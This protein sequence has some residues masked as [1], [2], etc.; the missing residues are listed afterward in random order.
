M[1]RGES[2]FRYLDA[3]TVAHEHANRTNFA[4]WGKRLKILRISAFRLEL[5]SK[6]A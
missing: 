3:Q 1:R 5:N 2:K 6:L 4:R